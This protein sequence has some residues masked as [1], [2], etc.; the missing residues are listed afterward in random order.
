[1]VLLVIRQYAVMIGTNYKHTF[2]ELLACRMMKFE[3]PPIGVP[4]D[5]TFRGISTEFFK[6]GLFAAFKVTA[7]NLFGQ[8]WTV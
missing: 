6:A 2:V 4:T 5:A 8:S 1:M 3:A 7:W